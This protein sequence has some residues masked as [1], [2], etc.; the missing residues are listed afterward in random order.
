[1]DSQPAVRAFPSGSMFLILRRTGSTRRS[2]RRAS[3]AAGSYTDTLGHERARRHRVKRPLDGYGHQPSAECRRD[4][5]DPHGDNMQARWPLR[6]SRG[7]QADSQ[8]SRASN[9]NGQVRRSILRL[10]AGQSGSD[11]RSH[12]QAPLSELPAQRAVRGGRQLHRKL[13]PQPGYSVV[14]SAKRASS[15]VGGPGLTRSQGAG[16]VAVAPPVRPRSGGSA[17][18]RSPRSTRPRS[19]S[20]RSSRPHAGPG[21]QPPRPGPRGLAPTPARAVM[22]CSCQLN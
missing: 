15:P 22:V 11:G 18:R 19:R 3:V 17:L 10:L 8:S 12:R 6:D 9:V 20:G 1:M 2:R 7:I 5:H 4:I 16:P 14:R 13:R 21:H